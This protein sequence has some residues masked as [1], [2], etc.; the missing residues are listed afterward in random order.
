M[1]LSAIRNKESVP[2]PCSGG[3]DGINRNITNSRKTE[4]RGQRDMKKW[5]QEEKGVG[6]R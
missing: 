4:G 3:R 5:H 1:A 6:H 2:G